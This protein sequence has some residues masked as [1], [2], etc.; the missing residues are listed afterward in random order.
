MANRVGNTTVSNGGRTIKVQVPMLKIGETVTIAINA[1]TGD[2]EI[3]KNI[4]VQPNATDEDEYE[5]I[6]GYF[7]TSSPPTVVVDTLRGR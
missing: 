5:P 4:T 2:D 1:F 6:T 3:E 7:W